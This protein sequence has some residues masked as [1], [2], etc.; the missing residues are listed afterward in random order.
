MYYPDLG[1]KTQI[2]DGEHVRAIGW[3]SADQPFTTGDVPAAFASRLRLLCEQWG[4]GISQ[5]WWV[6]AAGDHTCEL[7]GQFESS[8]NIGVPAGPLLFVAPEMVSHYVDTHGYRPPDAFVAAVLAC[9][10]PGSE[11][12][13]QAVA[14][15]RRINE[16]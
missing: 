5:L 6:V 12:Y 4:A 10:L 8:G 11:E 15:F 3:L 7:C 1:T 13:G 14:A 16:D 9:P 2:D